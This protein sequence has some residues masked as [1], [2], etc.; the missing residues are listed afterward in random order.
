M[1]K[2]QNRGDS[3]VTGGAGG[4]DKDVTDG[5]GEELLAFR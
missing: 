1:T 2:A 5:A 3:I 4:V